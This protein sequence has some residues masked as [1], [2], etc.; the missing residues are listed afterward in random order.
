[1]AEAT[2]TG[3]RSV[4][5][6]VRDL[7]NSLQFYESMWGLRKLTEDAGS[8][9]LRGCGPEHH[10]LHLRETPTPSLLSIHFATSSQA[11]VN[12]LHAKAVA[13]GAAI[14]QAPQSLPAIAGGGYGFA[15]L[16]PDGQ[17]LTI[18]AELVSGDSVRDASSPID[19]THVV[20]N[21][22]SADTQTDF[23]IDM[24]GFKLS[25]STKSMEFIR[26]SNDHHA[27]ALA[28]GSRPSMNHM[29]FKMSD[30]D[31]LMLASGRMKRNGFDIEW[32]VGR[33]G[34]GNNIFTYFIEPNGFVTEYT[35]GMDQI[36]NETYVPGTAEYWSDYP[37]RPCR[38]GVA[39]TP[40]ER[41]KR[42]FAGLLQPARQNGAPP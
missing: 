34:P 19:L 27:V 15:F 4:E 22:A 37:L 40:S 32:G 31:G 36:E 24:L 33:H 38:W 2:V 12:I 23:F 35:T 21:S 10:V 11:A 26:C 16:S 29:A 6:G 5:L 8:A 14:V 9:Y 13:F 30:L 39:M 41:V 20:L 25:D 18:S 42:G 28:R 7:R 1:M 17:K 3:L